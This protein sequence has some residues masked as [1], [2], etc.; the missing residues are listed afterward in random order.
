MATTYYFLD[1]EWADVMGGEP[2]SLALVNEGWDREFYAEP[3]SLPEGPTDFVRHCVYPL[4]DR[5]KQQ[6]LMSPRLP[7]CAPSLT[8]P[9]RPR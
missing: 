5:G 2:V 1:T 6:C 3:A 9:K 8:R 4:L 7:S